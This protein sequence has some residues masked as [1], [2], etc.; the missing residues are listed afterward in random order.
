[1]N[2]FKDKNILVVGASS[3]IG[4]QLA[5]EL[6]AASANLYTMSRN[7][8]QNLASTHI[9]AD[10]TALKGDELAGI[11]VLHGLAYCP[12]SINLKPFNRLS[13][14][15]FLNDFNINVLAAVQVLQ[16]ATKA[17]KNA[18]G[19]SV[20]LYST[21]A[22]QTGMGFHASI[23]ASKG[24][25]EGLVKSLAAEWAINK[26]RVNA[27]APSLTDT[28]LAKNLL[29]SDEKKETSGKRHPLGRI[30]TARDIA[31]L[32]SFLLSDNASWITG[33]IIGIDG[34]MSAVRLL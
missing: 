14:E 29:S 16:A 4:Y 7:M 20:V 25:V 19:A 15:D 1:M 13:K 32:S 9:T 8:P 23:A 27:I 30:G 5:S 18:N 10:V 6:L 2:I 28:P 11:E 24:A 33:Q 22:A 21:V 26:I 17:L 34:G 12:G 3:G 31:S